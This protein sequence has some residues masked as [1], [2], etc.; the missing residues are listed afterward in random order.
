MDRTE[1]TYVVDRGYFDYK[2]L[3]CLHN[4]GYFVVTR[5]KSNTTITVLE[6]IELTKRKTTDGQIISNQYVI[7]GGGNNHVTQRFRLMTILTK[8]QRLLRIV[9][10]CF[11]VSAT[12]VADMYQARWQIKLFFKHLKQNLTIKQLYSQSEQG[13]ILCVAL[14]V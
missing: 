14:K 13:A 10:N 9:S 2:L 11:D 12:E 5:T 1:A 6:Q 4:D 8:G 3:D 7:L